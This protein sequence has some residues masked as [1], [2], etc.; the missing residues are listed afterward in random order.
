MFD[1]VNGNRTA[2]WMFSNW[3]LCMDNEEPDFGAGLKINNVAAVK[4]PVQLPI[5]NKSIQQVGII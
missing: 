4:L 3:L 5:Q 2:L 1:T